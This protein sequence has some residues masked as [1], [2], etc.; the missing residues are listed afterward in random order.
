MLTSVQK[1][2]DVILPRYDIR[3]TAGSSFS[4]VG[5]LYNLLIPNEGDTSIMDS[6]PRQLMAPGLPV[7]NNSS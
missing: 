3:G 5:V 7:I 4:V 2:V 1:M 6:M